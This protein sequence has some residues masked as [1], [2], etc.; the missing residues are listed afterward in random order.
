MR[1]VL[2]AAALLAT[3]EALA[4]GVGLIGT[5]GLHTDQ[6]YFYDSSQ[7]L[8]QFPQV[9][10]AS[11][12]GA[13]AEFILGD[14]DDRIN[15]LFRG[16]WFRDSAQKNPAEVLNSDGSV[17]HGEVALAD[18]VQPENV[19]AAVRETPRD[20]GAA[21]FGVQWGLVGD[22]TKAQLVLI[23]ALGAGFLTND[24]SEFLTGNVGVG[25][26]FVVARDFQVIADVEYSARYRKGFSHG[27]NAFV[28]VRYLFD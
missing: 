25:A 19:E 11:S 7:S 6:V 22:P 15:G 23:T 3:T 9:Q 12:F 24:H 27:S 21:T 16:Y 14:R 4:G 8:T 20:V 10:L 18:P 1:F 2:A 28:G 17:K 13:G 5:G 26:T